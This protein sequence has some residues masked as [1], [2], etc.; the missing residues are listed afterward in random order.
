M[1]NST[2]APRFVFICCHVGAEKAL[3]SELARHRADLRFAFSQPGFVTFKIMEPCGAE[4]GTPL[5]SVFARTFGFSEGQ[6]SGPSTQAMAAEAA[7]LLPDQRFRHLHVW[8]RGC[9]PGERN[10]AVP[11]PQFKE[12]GECFQQ[13][14]LP[15]GGQ[16]ET[17]VNRTAQTGDW[18][19]DCVVFDKQNWWIGWHQATT[20]P[21]RWPGGV[22]VL[23]FDQ[24]VISRAYWKMQEALKW[25]RLPVRA[26]DRCV[27]IGSA[28][29]GACQA[30][31]EHGL[32]VVGIDPADMDPSLLGHRNFTHIRARVADLKRR[33][34]AGVP[35]LMADAN[36]APNY[37]LDALEGIVTHRHVNV[38][39]MLV[40]LKLI[41]WDTEHEVDAYLERIR[42]WGYRYVRARQLAFNGREICVLAIRRKHLLRHRPSTRD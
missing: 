35:W 13:Q 29:G 39:G 21:T 1:T 5:Q 14:R 31:L 4:M 2:I 15:K 37:T 10:S 6:V 9:D 26:G 41:D 25:S 38:Q 18:I 33:E 19:I 40:T 7:S 42:S 11:T 36:V 28:P 8:Q 23:K 27:E 20:V 34:F 16:L 17:F 3:K 24:E 12:I 30:L 32:H 22:P